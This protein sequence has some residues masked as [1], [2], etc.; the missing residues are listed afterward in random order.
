[1]TELGRRGALQLMAAAA[2][3]GLFARASAQPSTGYAQALVIDAL[4]GPGD[5]DA[6]KPDSLRLSARAVAD[7][8][9][10][11]ITACNLTVSAVG[12]IPES[13]ENTVRNIAASEYELAAHP[14]VLMKVRTATDLRTAKAT[15]RV[16]LI[17][18]FQDTMPVGTDLTR[19]DRFSDLG[20]RVVQLTYNKRNLVGDGCLEPANAGLSEYGRAMVAKINSLNLLVD[21]SHAGQRTIAEGI[22]ASKAPAAI[23]HTGC[24]ALA[25]LPRNTRDEELRALADKGGVAG[26]YF[27]PFLR[28]S[29]QPHGED[30]IRHIE[31]AVQVAGED[32]VGLGTDGMISAIELTPAFRELHRKDIENRRRMGVSAP[33]ETADV[34]TFVP[35]YNGPRKFERLAEDLRRRGHAWAR[36]EKILGGNFARLF[37]EVWRA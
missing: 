36:L 33:G 2:G 4:G 10:S 12:N 32:H 6:L 26:I 23:T 17:Y 19:L 28:S 31:H 37:A 22:A 13:F 24:R 8:K 1:M 7:A 5:M 30:L 9:A 27:M 16:G 20:L 11:G 14:D 18:G 34:F 3:A 15:R 29:G 21:L 35:E 25:D